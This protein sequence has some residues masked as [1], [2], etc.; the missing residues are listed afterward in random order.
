MRTLR[1]V[2]LSLALGAVTL[3]G[4]IITQAQIL[5]HFELTN[6][7]QIGPPPENP[8]HREY[9]DLN[10]E[11]DEYADHKDDLQGLTD[12]AVVG[13]FTNVTPLGPNNTGGTLE[14]WITSGDTNLSDP[15][16]GGATKLWGPKSIGPNPAS[17]TISWDESATLF[18]P[19]GKQ[20]LIDIV[21]GEGIFTAYVLTTGGAAAQSFEV[22][23][24]A[25][26]LVLSA[27]P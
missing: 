25:I 7:F 21:K 16:S 6:P 27:G 18:D 22:K 2:L 11:V 17:V 19:V 14:V 12:L 20:L 1:T 24:G 5:A 26:I 23:D 9:I 10:V 13:T 15:A 3:T 4:C 8:V